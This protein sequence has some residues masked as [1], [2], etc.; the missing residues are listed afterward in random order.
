MRPVH[1][2]LL[3][4]VLLAAAAPAAAATC[5]PTDTALCLNASRFQLE[6]AWKDFGGRTGVGHAVPLT[7]DTGYFWF[8]DSANVELVVKVLDGR[9]LNGKFWVFFGALSNV[10]YTLTVRDTVTGSTKQYQNPAGR[11]AS[12]AD[13]AAF[14]AAAAARASHTATVAAGTDS[15]PSSLAEI[16]DFLAE[17][18]VAAASAPCPEARFALHL[19][20]CRFRVEVEWKVSRQQAGLGRPVPLTDDTGYFWFFDPANV[21]LVVKVL[22]G[23][24]LNGRYWV[25]FGALTD[26]EYTLVVTD[27][28]TKS[29]KRYTNP[30]GKLASVGDTTALRAGL[31][32]VSVPD[33][34][35]AVSADLDGSGG[36]L[37]ATG[38]DGSRFTLELPPHS[39]PH[40]ATV[41]L[42]PVSRIDGFPFSGGL[43]AGVEIEPEGLRLLQ[44]A[45][46]TIQPAASVPANQILTYSY[47]R[48]GDELGLHPR[49]LGNP[50]IRLPLLHFSGYGAGAGTAAEANSQSRSAMGDLLAPYV[51]RYAYWL[52]LHVWGQI[53][54][55]VL[56]DHGADIFA[57]AFREVAEPLFAQARKSCDRAEIELAAHVGFGIARYIQIYG[58]AEDPR[59]AHI[60]P[61]VFE[62]AL[63]VLETCMQ[64]AFDRCVAYTDPFEATLMLHIARQLQ[65][66]GV[67]DPYLTS[68]VQGGLLERCLRFELD[69]QSKIAEETTIGNVSWVARQ[70]YRSQRVPLRLNLANVWAHSGAWEGACTLVPEIQTFQYLA[71]PEA[72]RCQ[73]TVSPANGWFD[74]AAAWIG[75]LDDPSQSAIRL[76]YHPGDPEPTASINCPGG[77]APN[78]AWTLFASSYGLFHQDELA[79]SGLYMARGWEQLR[80]GGGPSQNG[81]FFAKKSYERTRQGP[82]GAQKLTEETWFF[83]KHTPDAPMPNCP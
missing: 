31:S 53:P 83:L 38:A 28:V 30:R 6:V 68:F 4:Y 37:T 27:T 81:E 23:R 66:F 77:S 5:A 45:T 65:V 1:A 59:V 82:V 64:R 58:L 69:F 9:G 61:R 18:G 78:F 67:D 12:V 57:D 35:H 2:G 21:E 14:G 62:L 24:P 26:V 80:F 75:V 25:F 29:V 39:L 13:T 19:G 44:P 72:A 3:V 22:D 71:P 33:P 36:T 46:L 34:A 74:G 32:A 11:F 15:T 50:A 16:A 41:T 76:L 51:Q 79:P 56:N 40:P 49:L 7:A 52:S 17:P 47:G 8:F 43:V 73:V 48:S 42:T 63:D 60:T 54:R 10:E 70:R 55:D 20:G